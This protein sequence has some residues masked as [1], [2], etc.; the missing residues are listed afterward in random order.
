MRAV[1]NPWF[2]GFEN[3]RNY[4]IYV[5]GRLKPGVTLDQASARINTPYHSIINEVEAPLQ[6]GMSEQTMARFRARSLTL[7]DGRRGQS[8]VHGEARAPLIFLFGITG[9]V[10]LIACANIA[11]LLLA[12]GAQRSGE[13]AVRLALGATRGRILTQLLT[14]SMVLALLGGVASLLV[15]TWTL[16]GIGSCCRKRRPTPFTFGSRVRSSYSPACWRSPPGSSSACFRR[17]TVRG[18]T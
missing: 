2:T 5:F 18:R 11:N 6:E 1:M 13:I 3:R 9:L 17:S 10:L 4:W 7:E 12:R 14:E 16:W 15:A 8:S